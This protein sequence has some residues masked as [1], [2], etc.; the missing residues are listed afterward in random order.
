MQAGRHLDCQASHLIH[1]LQKL[2]NPLKNEG[3]QE[4]QRAVYPGER[5]CASVPSQ[6]YIWV[7]YE[8]LSL[9]CT[10]STC[11]A[12]V[13]IKVMDAAALNKAQ[14]GTAWHSTAARLFQARCEQPC[15]ASCSA[16]GRGQCQ[17]TTTPLWWTKILWASSYTLFAWE[18]GDGMLRRRG[19]DPCQAANAGCKRRRA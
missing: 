12:H 4:G 3:W 6:M 8:S 10:C 1:I 7:S 9:S 16:R 18:R 13:Q 17:S 5:G 15:R 14:H 19:G 11:H 2:I